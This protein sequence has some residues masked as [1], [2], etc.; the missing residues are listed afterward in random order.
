MSGWGNEDDSSEDSEEKGKSMQG[1]SGSLSFPVS[2]L[3][4][5]M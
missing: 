3:A 1:E 5:G 4:L 2:L